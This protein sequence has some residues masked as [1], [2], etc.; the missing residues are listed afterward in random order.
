MNDEE[1]KKI[2]LTEL[3]D[4]F[5]KLGYHVLQI[6]HN[7]ASLREYTEKLGLS[8]E[9]LLANLEFT[10]KTFF[11]QATAKYQEYEQIIVRGE[12]DGI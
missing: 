6:G 12:E 7:I 5:D 10:L 4:T 8:N 11:E 1:L 2:T 9:L 3:Q